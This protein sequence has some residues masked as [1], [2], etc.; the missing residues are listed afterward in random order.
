MSIP[1]EPGNSSGGIQS[2]NAL[3]SIDPQLRKKVLRM[4]PYGIHVITSRYEE[5][6]AAATIDWVTQSSFEPPMVVCCLRQDSF[7]Y[8]LVTKSK[9]YAIHPLGKEQKSFAT[10]FFKN[11]DSDQSHINGQSYQIGKT[12]VP[13][14]DEAPA[15]FELEMVDQLTQSDHAVIL[16]KVVAVDLKIE[17][18]ALL[19]QDTGWIYGG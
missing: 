9:R 4:I 14:L 7:I 1:I 15:S 2:I 13:I 18:P 10:H 12:G 8:E 3:P 17:T 6:V 11:K 5:K 19:L 16:G